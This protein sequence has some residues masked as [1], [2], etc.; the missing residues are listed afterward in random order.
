VTTSFAADFPL[1]PAYVRKVFFALEL[2]DAVTLERVTE[3]VSVTV[4][5]LRRRPIV[6]RSGVFVWLD[7]GVDA[8]GDVA[9][10]PG[11]RPYADVDLPAAQVKRQLTTISLAPRADYPFAGGVTGLRGALVENRADR[12]PVADADVHLGWLDA[13]SASWRDAPTV[14]RT[15]A[16]G[17]FAVILRLTPTDA[18]TVVAGKVT[19]RLRVGRAEQGARESGDLALPRGRVADPSTFAAD[20][21]ALV[22]AWEELQQP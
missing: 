8:P 22:F 1:E 12:V 17:D 14:G 13:D 4:G 20:R 19:V 2:V 11:L 21:D 5:G 16:H 7:E 3:G 10:R 9:V 6:N 15:N 18:P